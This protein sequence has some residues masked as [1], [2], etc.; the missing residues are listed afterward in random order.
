M[1]TSVAW[2]TNSIRTSSCK[3]LWSSKLKSASAHDRVFDAQVLTYLRLTGL[4][5]GL[6]LNFGRPVLKDGIK[7]FV[8]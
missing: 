2:K 1:Q 4:R 5:T 8:L 6:L 3:A 7:R